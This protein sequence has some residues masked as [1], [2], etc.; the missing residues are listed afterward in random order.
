[1]AVYVVGHCA[2]MSYMLQIDGDILL[3]YNSRV[4]PGMLVGYMYML[5][6][7]SLK[8]TGPH[9]E[10]VHCRSHGGPVQFLEDGG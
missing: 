6:C 2:N 8:L 10:T 3:S 7:Y 9:M 4:S 5:D 1:M